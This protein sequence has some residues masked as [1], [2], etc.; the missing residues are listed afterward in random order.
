MGA[1]GCYTGAQP[2]D[3][4]PQLQ[5]PCAGNKICNAQSDA[6]QAGALFAEIAGKL[7]LGAGLAEAAALIL[8]AL[9]AALAG[10]IWLAW[11][12]PIVSGLG[13]LVES[14]ATAA[15]GAA[16]VMGIVSAEFWSQGSKHTPGDWSRSAMESFQNE[17][18]VTIAVGMTIVTVITFTKTVLGSAATKVGSV[19]GSAQPALLKTVQLFNN[20]ANIIAGANIMSYADSWIERMDSDL[21]YA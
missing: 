13:A 17:V 10:S 9:A 1:S 3:S 4:G 18:G 2:T 5:D 8:E 19:L 11:L 15:A 16:G 21:G 14:P 20:Y 6:N 12:A 7:L